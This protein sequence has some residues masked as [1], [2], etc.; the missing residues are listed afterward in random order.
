MPL[1]H[2]NQMKTN[3]IDPGVLKGGGHLALPDE[4][5]PHPGVVVIHEIFGL[6][7]NIKDIA[8][9]FADQGYAALAVDLFGGR[10]RAVC[11][12][13]FMTGMLAGSVDR[14]GIADLKAA[15]TH[16]AGLPEVDPKR[17][18]AIGFCMG[19]GFAIAWACTDDRLKA[20]A[21]FY[22]ANPRPLDAVQRACPVVGSYPEKDFTAGAG[23][24]LDKALDR[25]GIAH[26]I[27]IYPGAGHSFFNDRGRAY[28]KAAATDSWTRVLGFFG[29]HLAPS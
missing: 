6:N 15:L 17:I 8:G 25:H 26:D 7:E 12:A 20:I 5:G 1:G 2:P 10:N 4:P 13:R 11:M 23:R 16:L 21:P 27:K 18:G 14:F 24:A 9:R 22:G 29:E 19:G 28:D 3:E